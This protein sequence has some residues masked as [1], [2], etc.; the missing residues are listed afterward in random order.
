[1][2]RLHVHVNRFI[3]NFS[4]VTCHYNIHGKLLFMIILF[5]QESIVGFRHL[6]SVTYCGYFGHVHS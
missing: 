6:Q 5:S 2:T 4:A 1:M 3:R